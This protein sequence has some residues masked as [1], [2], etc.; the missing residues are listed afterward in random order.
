MRR[1]V[2]VIEN[3][4]CKSVSQ[5]CQSDKK[6]KRD[7]NLKLN[8]NL[9]EFKSRMGSNFMNLIPLSPIYALFLLE[10]EYK[11]LNEENDELCDTLDEKDKIIRN[12][13]RKLELRSIQPGQA[14]KSELKT[15]V[16]A[17]IIDSPV[18][19]EAAFYLP[20]IPIND[21]TV[22][23]EVEAEEF[24]DDMILLQARG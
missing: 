2:Q 10:E 3:T 14:V 1:L 21:F 5:D 9:L 6:I 22:N 18:P 11:K 13:E 7:K 16:I 23:K 15:K 4:T 24:N 20:L 17:N 12:L 19:E 8:L